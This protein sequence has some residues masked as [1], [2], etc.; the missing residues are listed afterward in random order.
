MRLISAE[1]DSDGAGPAMLVAQLAE[2]AIHQDF[3]FSDEQNPLGERLNILHVVRREDD[4]GAFFLV[5]RFDKLPHGNFGDS[6][7]PNGRLIQ[8]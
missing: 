3:S 1:A 5:E 8:K 2:R 6:V 7:Q 4:R